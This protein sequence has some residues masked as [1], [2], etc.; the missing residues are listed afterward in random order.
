MNRIA[1]IDSWR[2]LA[3]LSVMAF[4]Y[5]VRFAPPQQGEDLYGFAYVYPAALELG[6]YGV[7]VFFVI[8]GMVITMTLLRSRNVIDFGFR[9]FARL[10][11]AFVVC[12]TFTFIFVALAG[13][14]TLRV[15]GADYLGN[16]TMLADRL[17]LNFVDGAYWS[18]AVEVE[19][20][21]F[22]AAAW[23]VL[24]QRFWIGMIALG[25]L[26]AA[27]R[28]FDPH[29]ADMLLLARYMPYF[30]AGMSAWFILKER[31]HRAG[32]ML[33]LAAAALFVRHAPTLLLLG[34]PSIVAATAVL[35]AVGMLI[36]SVVFQL[37]HPLL[38]WIGRISY[39]LYL[40]HENVGVTIIRQAKAWAAPDWIAIGLAVAVSVLLAWACH[41]WVERPS[42]E[43]L[44]AFWKRRGA[45]AGRIRAAPAREPA[46][47]GLEPSYAQPSDGPSAPGEGQ[48]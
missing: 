20:Y 41:E 4:H 31:R 38:A 23:L 6:R 42:A 14:P 30:L 43:R 7:E 16:L 22:V 26:G 45:S 47:S 3:I 17:G 13:P 35:A 48:S 34:R 19:F 46:L 11:P 10:Y 21:A 28:R 32:A 36:A 5:L 2:A 37:S 18:L 29:N 27:Y 33:G 40:I 12:M 1:A 39:P 8:S 44:R 9:R 15:S 25:V 24:K